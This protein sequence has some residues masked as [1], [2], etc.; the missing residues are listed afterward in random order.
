MDTVFRSTPVDHPHPLRPQELALGRSA[1]SKKPSIDLADFVDVEKAKTVFPVTEQEL[2]DLTTLVP[3]WPMFG[4]DRFGDCTCAGAAH[5]VQVFQA[6]VGDAFTVT[7]ADVLRMYEASGW[8]PSK[9]ETDQGWSLEAAGEYLEK[10]G[11]QGTPNIVTNA[12]V[13]LT[14]QDAQQVA[15]EL[16]GGLYEGMECPQSAL[17]QFQEGKPWTVVPGS[18][19]A[20]GHCVT[21]PKN[22]IGVTGYHVTW[23]GI[24][25]ATE[26]FE[27]EFIDELVVFVPVAWESKLPEYILQAGIVDFAKLESLVSQFTS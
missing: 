17:Q 21:R 9:P 13:S 2:V 6:L 27:N 7:E 15:L 23:G 20:G 12:G 4:N 14:D 18:T 3:S 8:S 26:E 24:I 16:F 25:P 1:R 10:T 19:I 22:K 5:M 11:L